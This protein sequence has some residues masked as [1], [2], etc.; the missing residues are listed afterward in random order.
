MSQDQE[1]IEKTLFEAPP[2]AE[3]LLYWFRER[4]FLP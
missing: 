2:W 1:P 3:Q 4:A